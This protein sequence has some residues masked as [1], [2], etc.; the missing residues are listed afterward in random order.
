MN[1]QPLSA[2]YLG[3]ISRI[4]GEGAL[5]FGVVIKKFR[6]SSVIFGGIRPKANA[7]PILRFELPNFT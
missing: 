3:G 7:T 5:F 6:V 2:L 1:A 4:S